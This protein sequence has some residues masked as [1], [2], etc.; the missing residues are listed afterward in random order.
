MNSK[1]QDALIE[2]GKEVEAMKETPA[3]TEIIID[4]AKLNIAIHDG[5]MKGMRKH[6]RRLC[7][8]V[9]KMMV[10]EL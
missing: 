1:L 3:F 7:A 2:I 5:D 10:D 8:L 4:Q 6:G 9:T